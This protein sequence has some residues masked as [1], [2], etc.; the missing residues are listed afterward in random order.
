[1]SGSREKGDN[2]RTQSI[3]SRISDMVMNAVTTPGHLP[4]M[5]AQQDEY[6]AERERTKGLP[7]ALIWP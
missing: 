7:F 5:T 4:V 6:A 2:G 1:M 3:S